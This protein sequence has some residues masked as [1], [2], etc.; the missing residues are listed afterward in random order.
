M[1]ESIHRRTVWGFEANIK[2]EHQPYHSR[3]RRSK[4]AEIILKKAL[5]RGALK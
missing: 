4:E 1:L 2:N 3:T 5:Y